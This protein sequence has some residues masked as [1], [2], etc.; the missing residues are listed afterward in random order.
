M[1]RDIVL[2]E[3]AR[4]NVPPAWIFAIIRTESGGN[5]GSIGR[6]DCARGECSYGL[7]G[8]KLS[9]A[10]GLD[11]SVTVQ[12]LM[13]P[14]KNIEIGAMYLAQLRRRFSSPEDVFSYYKGGHPWATSSPQAKKEAQQAMLAAGQSAVMVAT[15]QY[16]RRSTLAAEA[17]MLSG[18]P[19]P[20][21]YIAGFMAL[22]ALLRGSL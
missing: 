1:I 10:R 5:P 21:F 18:I 6:G 2:N 12:E 11:P 4:W 8:I 14:E 9:T 20:V 16:D 13:T 15:G 17:G 22:I 3:A 7:M 19:K